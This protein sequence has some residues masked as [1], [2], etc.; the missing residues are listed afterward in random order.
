MVA[1]AVGC[2]EITQT[3]LD[4]GA[5]PSYAND[6][7]LTPLHVA[8]KAGSSH[9]I[10][11]LIG[12]GANPDARLTPNY[13]GLTALHEASLRTRFFCVDELL[14]AGADE[15][16]KSLPS[17][18]SANPGERSRSTT[19]PCE[20]APID[21]IG[22]GLYCEGEE[23]NPNTRCGY[24]TQLDIDTRREPTNMAR[25]RQLLQHAPANRR[26][27]RRSW[28]VIMKERYDAEAM[29]LHQKK[30][31]HESHVGE[32]DVRGPHLGGDDREEDD[33]GSIQPPAQ[34]QGNGSEK[35]AKR[36]R[37][38]EAG[39]QES[40]ATDKL[41]RRKATSVDMAGGGENG[42][43]TTARGFTK[44]IPGAEDAKQSSSTKGCSKLREVCES[45]FTL[46]EQDRDAF[47]L[48]MQF[49]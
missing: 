28:V 32:P 9:L 49:L 18:A 6:K 17:S 23:I 19:Q 34:E 22:A 3:L 43:L 41:K 10:K 11:M 15:M 16:L 4:H 33:R 5:N 38:D 26:W 40:M 42:K 35:G 7:G 46:A 8:A 2:R 27:R 45:L 36:Q 30:V 44:H 29:S 21:V 20:K 24:E 13:L 25:V 12:A 31:L 39:T 14:K 48:V 37:S 47:R 1:A